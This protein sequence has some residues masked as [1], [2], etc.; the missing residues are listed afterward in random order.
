MFK[1][2]AS[3]IC[4]P[5]EPASGSSSFQGE[6]HRLDARFVQFQTTKTETSGQLSALSFSTN[7]QASTAEGQEAS[8]SKDASSDFEF[9]HIP[10][11][12]D[13]SSSDSVEGQQPCN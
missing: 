5:L 11:L 7:Q 6:T 9:S 1:Q 10:G 12:R 3:T 4:E 13:D 8:D 2:K